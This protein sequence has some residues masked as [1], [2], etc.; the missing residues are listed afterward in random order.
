VA[1]SPV[2]WKCKILYSQTTKG[3]RVLTE[4]QRNVKNTSQDRQLLTHEMLNITKHIKW[5]WTWTMWPLCNI[6]PQAEGGLFNSIICIKSLPV[7]LQ[8]I[9]NINFK[10]CYRWH[11]F[12][13]ITILPNHSTY[14]TFHLWPW[15]PLAN[16]LQK[17]SGN[18]GIQTSINYK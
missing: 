2:V 15:A 12:Q 11:R 18:S 1:T 16:N 17:N 8:L 4:L 14:T 6:K 7:P 5:K 10:Y 9:I 13:P 3:D